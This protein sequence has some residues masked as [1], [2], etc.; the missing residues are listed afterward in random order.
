V[1][2]T[3]LPI[4]H[5]DPWVNLPHGYVTKTMRALDA[6]GIRVLDSWLDPYGPRDATIRYALRGGHVAP[7]DIL[8]LVWDEVSGWRQGHFV[9]GHQGLRTKLTWVA[10]LGGG[11]LPDP[12][13]VTWR[14]TCGEREAASRYRSCA[15]YHDGLDEALLNAAG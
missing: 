10:Y 5:P 8:A 11:V 3:L 7:S 13:E 6:R 2:R 9:E 4:S 12:R 14:L 1:D 15:D